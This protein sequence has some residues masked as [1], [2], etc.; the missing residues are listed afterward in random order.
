[1]NTVTLAQLLKI[2]DTEALLDFR[3]PTSG[4]LLWP[5]ARIQ[6]LRFIMS[7]LFYE[8]PLIDTG[9]RTTPRHALATLGRAVAHNAVRSRRMHG[10]VMLMGTG[11]GLYMRNGQ[12]YNRLADPFVDAMAGNTVAVEDFLDWRW[13]M[14]RHQP[15]VL[16]HAPMQACAAIYGRFVTSSAHTEL[17][18]RL[19]NLVRQRA[20]QLIGWDLDDARAAFL[21]HSIA[22]HTAAIPLRRSAYRRMFRRAGTRLLLKEEGCYG[23]SSIAIQVA[24]ELGILT[25]EYQHGSVSAGNEAYNLAPTLASSQEYVRTLP[26]YFLGYGQW[27]NDQI[28]V[29][30]GKVVIGNP[31]RAVQTAALTAPALDAGNAVL[32]LGDG[33]ETDRYLGFASDLAVELKHRGRTELQVKFRPHP[34][35]RSQVEQRFATNPVLGVKL[36]IEADIYRS[37]NGTHAVM[38]EVSTGLFEAIGLAQHVFL[39]DTPKARF[40]YPSYPFSAVTSPAEL[41]AALASDPARGSHIEAPEIWATDWYG[42][43]MNFVRSVG[44]SVERS[45]TMPQGATL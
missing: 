29:P 15:Q 32:I 24:R 14:P 34:L 12:W 26:D 35:E 13:P 5:L 39:W 22:R 2:E 1:M 21:I 11:L 33:I 16:F 30:I 28:S 4:Y 7:D 37:L 3:C 36:D 27:W 40:C 44:V 43:Y 8:R 20:H 17:A 38:S 6:F 45:S 31:H 23:P 18:T 41:A 9:P 25:A 19:V 42:R 10:D